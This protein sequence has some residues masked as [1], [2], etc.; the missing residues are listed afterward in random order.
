[1]NT[2]LFGQYLLER[3]V[4]DREQL[5]QALQEQQAADA[6][7]GDL[8]VAIGLLAVGD[9]HAIRLEQLRKDESFERAAQSLGLLTPSQCLELKDRQRSRKVLLSQI[10]L[11]RGYADF[12]QL[13]LAEYDYNQASI[14]R[15]RELENLL[16]RA[17]YGEV[18]SVAVSVLERVYPRLLGDTLR[19]QNATPEHPIQKGARAWTQQLVADS[20][21]HVMGLQ[22]DEASAVRIAEVVLGGAL[23]G[24][25][26]LAEDAVS[27]FLNIV[28]GHVCGNLNSTPGGV[29]T[30]PPRVMSGLELLRDYRDV[31]VLRCDS[32]DVQFHFVFGSGVETRSR[33]TRSYSPSL[34]LEGVLSGA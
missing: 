15:S 22:M 4:V 32:G 27:E 28:L 17:N 21:V 9:L 10:L 23:E 34:R 3:G 26:E 19:I 11:S 12:D 1:M 25:D 14:A 20:M 5:L 6:N 13:I 7:M 33:F 2:K 30:L 16:A 24:F 8:A 29:Q 31:I 18:A